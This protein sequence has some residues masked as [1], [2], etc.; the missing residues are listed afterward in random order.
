MAFRQ[1][2]PLFNHYRLHSTIP[3]PRPFPWKS[4]TSVA[5]IGFGLGTVGAVSLAEFLASNELFKYMPDND[6]DGDGKADDTEEDSLQ[7]PKFLNL[8]GDHRIQLLFH[9]NNRDGISLFSFPAF[10]PFIIS[11]WVSPCQNQTWTRLGRSERYGV[12][13]IGS[14]WFRQKRTQNYWRV[15]KEAS[16]NQS[17]TAAA[18]KEELLEIVL[19]YI[20][21]NW[22]IL[23]R[24]N[25]YYSL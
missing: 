12:L 4:L 22:S 5:L 14:R 20:V 10:I 16:C 24:I 11:G 21:I 7:Q 17:G 6:E 19:S 9:W 25:R 1:F 8:F 15:F 18:S 13:A 23:L 3:A 2:R